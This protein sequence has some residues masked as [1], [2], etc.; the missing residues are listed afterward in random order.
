MILFKS[1]QKPSSNNKLYLYCRELEII[2]ILALSFVA[3]P[4]TIWSIVRGMVAFGSN[5]VI[6]LTNDGN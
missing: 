3:M 1:G 4:L 5:E 2:F 6:C